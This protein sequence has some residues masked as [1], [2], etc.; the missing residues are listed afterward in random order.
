MLD[1]ARV[2]YPYLSV[3]VAGPLCL[4][5]GWHWAAL[6]FT[7]V[8]AFVVAKWFWYRSCVTL[9]LIV[10]NAA[11]AMLALFFI[12]RD[13]RDRLPPPPEVAP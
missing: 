1:T 9:P 3:L 10:W 13:W 8:G 6:A 4:I 5:L 7:A 12:V 11:E 2:F